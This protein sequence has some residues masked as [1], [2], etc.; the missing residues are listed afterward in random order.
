[1]KQLLVALI[2]IYLIPL[3]GY[4]SE[5]VSEVADSIWTRPIDI[6]NIDLQLIRVETVI[7]IEFYRGKKR[8]EVP[9]D[10]VDQNITHSEELTW[11]T[12]LE[13]LTYDR[14][15]D[16]IVLIADLLPTAPAKTYFEGL[17]FH[18]KE[19]IQ[20]ASDYYFGKIRTLLP[21]LSDHPDCFQAIYRAHNIDGVRIEVARQTG[22]DIQHINLSGKT[23]P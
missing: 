5:R 17:I 2:G 6:C 12:Y 14:S 15:T 21:F 3:T 4:S 11:P 7:W 20:E 18:R 16:T 9:A 19:Q 23:K 13:S 8:Y 10:M 1:M 22:Y